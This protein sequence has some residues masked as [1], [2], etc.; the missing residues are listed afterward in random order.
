MKAAISERPK[1]ADKVVPIAQLV[2]LDLDL[3]VRNPNQPREYFD[4]GK[5]KL[6]AETIKERGDI[7][8]AVKV[9]RYQDGLFMLID[10]ERR[11][12]AAKLA[13]V[14]AISAII[15]PRLSE[16]EMYE[17]SSLLNFCKEEM[18]FFEK[19][20]AFDRIMKERGINQ[21]QLEKLIGVPQTEI[22][23]YLKVLNLIPEIQQ[24]L[25]RQ[26]IGIALALNLSN[27]KPEHQLGMFKAFNELVEKRGKPFNIIEISRVIRKIAEE[28]GFARRSKK[29][30]SRILSSD[31]M[32][33]K[34]FE[35]TMT[36]FCAEL[37]RVCDLDRNQLLKLKDP[38]ARMVLQ[39]I[40]DLQE[41]LSQAE[42]EISKKIDS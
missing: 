25:R 20:R 42:Q 32:T 28:K 35:R 24:L 11:W 17:I 2:K 1:A 23:N 33:G 6:L 21:V 15:K 8:D 3:I 36:N 5:L 9:S 22:S 7:E 39:F 29:H 19:A 30:E 38:S 12:R 10:G 13:G 31:Q 27:F 16:S 37:S 41:R 26:E 34:A 4:P 18:T 40:E 14:S